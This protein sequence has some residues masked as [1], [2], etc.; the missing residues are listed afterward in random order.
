MRPSLVFSVFGIATFA[1]LPVFASPPR[2]GSPE[3]DRVQLGVVDSGGAACPRDA[4]LTAWAHTKGP[5]P[6]RFVIHNSGG[7]ETGELQAQAV[8]GAAGTYLATYKHTFK[9]T[10]DV[11]TEYMAEVAGSGQSSNWV[12]LSAQCG[13]R[14]RAETSARGASPQPPARSASESRA[15]AS[16]G[17]STAGG[18]PP[19]A[20]TSPGA[21]PDAGGPSEGGSKPNS[22]GDSKPNSP[23][24]GE[25]KQC[26]AKITSTRV[27]VVSRVLGLEA[28]HLM[29]RAAVRQAHPNSWDHWG[30]A[31]ERSLDCKR[32]GLLWNCTVSARP[33]AP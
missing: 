16:T 20:R 6:V 29:W 32:A 15:R 11:E 1:S 2:A 14:A 33:C 18:G 19:P 3:V 26:G 8:P 24:D 23:G 27:G 30:N 13:P 12:S 7:G 25:A 5:G 4:T 10:T 31:R 17:T 28:A 21:D 22:G 9:I